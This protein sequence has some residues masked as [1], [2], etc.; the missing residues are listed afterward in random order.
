MNY[1]F[2]FH[3][4]VR[5]ITISTCGMYEGIERFIDE[6]RP[7]NLAI[8]LNDTDMVKRA[9]HMPVEKKYPMEK[10]I[11]LL[12]NKFPASRNRV[13]IEYIM[14][15]DNISEEDAMRLK[16]MFRYNRIKLNLIPLKQRQA[17]LRNSNPGRNK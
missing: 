12:E 9:R 13:T 8:S 5:K 17:Y 15:K 1:T 14:R 16:T 4:S 2:G 11:R 3:I 10:I 6:K 7:Y